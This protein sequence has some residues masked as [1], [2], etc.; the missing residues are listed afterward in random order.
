MLRPA[1]NPCHL[2]RILDDNSVAPLRNEMIAGL[3]AIDLCTGGE[4]AITFNS[5]RNAL[6]ARFAAGRN[7]DDVFS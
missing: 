4:L 6:H 5:P 2:P 7:E 1:N 3:K